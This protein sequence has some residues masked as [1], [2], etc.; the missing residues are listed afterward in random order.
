MKTLVGIATLTLAS[1]LAVAQTVSLSEPETA[2]KKE[3][4]AKVEVEPLVQVGNLQCELGQVVVLTADAAAP[5]HFNLRFGKM[6]YDVFTQVTTTGAVRL[7]DKAAEIVWLQ[8][9]NKSM[10]MNQKK[11]RR[12]ADECKSP[13]QARVAL[14]LLKN[15][16]QS[17]LDEPTPIAVVK[18]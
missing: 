11:G 18:P 4:E 7:E 5:G 6:S 12:L 15:P 13:L 16:R 3:V 2:A 14:E 8:L 17:V 9:A 10:L 1:T